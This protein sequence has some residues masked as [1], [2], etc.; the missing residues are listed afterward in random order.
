V[1]TFFPQ[2]T[3]VSTLPLMLHKQVLCI[4]VPAI[5]VQGMLQGVKLGMLWRNVKS[6]FCHRSFPNHS[7][8]KNKVYPHIKHDAESI[9]YNNQYDRCV[10]TKSNCRYGVALGY[11]PIMGLQLGSQGPVWAL[12]LIIKLSCACALPAKQWW[13]LAAIMLQ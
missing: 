1:G 5:F 8:N 10:V 7:Y 2:K 9:K 6:P 3:K 11:E 4:V 13:P 12:T